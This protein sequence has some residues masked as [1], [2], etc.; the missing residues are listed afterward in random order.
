MLFHKKQL[1]EQS[2]LLLLC[3]MPFILRGQIKKKGED[4]T[5]AEPV[6]QIVKISP[7][8][9]IDPF[10][11]TFTAYFEQ[12]LRSRKKWTSFETEVGY[13]FSV[14]GLSDE[15]WGYRLRSAYRQYRKNKWKESG[16][17]YL[18]FALMQRQIFDKGSKFLWRA[19]RNF[20]QNLDYQLRISQQSAAINWGFMRYFG[21]NNAFNLDMSIGLGFRRSRILFKGLP[22]DAITPDVPDIYERNFK[23]YVGQTTVKD[24]THLFY[25]T[26][27]GIKLGYVLQKNILEPKK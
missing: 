25:S 2:L 19:D 5:K 15:A 18:S 22:D 12:Q 27:L 24:R 20:Q 6:E 26:A 23:K 10:G 1:I 13:T 17:S 3:L 4:Q 9:M 8:S 11:P 14:T 7:I 21:R 16:N